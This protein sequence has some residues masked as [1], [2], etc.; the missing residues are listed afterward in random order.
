VLRCD[1]GL[2]L[3]LTSAAGA[4]RLFL[5]SFLFL[6]FTL[7]LGPSRHHGPND[8][9]SGSSDDGA[10]PSLGLWQ[11]DLSI[12]TTSLL[13]KSATRFKKTVAIWLKCTGSHHLLFISRNKYVRETWYCQSTEEIHTAAI[14]SERRNKISVK[15]LVVDDHARLL[16]RYYMY[17]PSTVGA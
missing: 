12:I 3:E 10:T 16:C 2:L 17:L 8:Y 1:G 9:D 6:A 14:S 5:V 7:V 4:D 15:Q 13:G 11:V